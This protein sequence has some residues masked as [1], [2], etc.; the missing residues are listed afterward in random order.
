MTRLPLGQAETCEVLLKHYDVPHDA[1]MRAPGPIVAARIQPH[2][3]GTFDL[4]PEGGR[5][6]IVMPTDLEDSDRGSEPLDL[7]AF[8]PSDPTHWWLRHGVAR[9]LGAWEVDRRTLHFGGPNLCPPPNVENSGFTVE[10]LALWRNPLTW[11]QAGCVGAVPLCEQALS[12]LIGLEVAIVPEDLNHANQIDA[13][14]R[15]PSQPMPK[16]A[17]RSVEQGI[18]L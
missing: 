10:P 12:D 3:D 18:Q 11:L 14:L 1:A 9:W 6:A 2:D 16:I 8:F 17:L 7:L 4:D 13:F 15:G 5:I